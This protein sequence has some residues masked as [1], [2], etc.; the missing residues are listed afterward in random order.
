MTAL[1]IVNPDFRIGFLGMGGVMVGFGRA[2][3][4]EN[5]ID[6]GKEK[7]IGLVR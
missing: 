7:L 4:V 1:R 3:F 5:R 2:Q 6:L